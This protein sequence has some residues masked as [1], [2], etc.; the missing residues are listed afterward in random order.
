MNPELEINYGS[1]FENFAVC[2]L[3]AIGY[4]IY[5]YKKQNIGEIDFLIERDGGILPVEVKSGKD[6]KKHRSLDLLMSR[7][8]GTI[9]EAVVLSANNLEQS[10]PI[11]YCPIYMASL[12][13]PEKIPEETIDIHLFG[14][15]PS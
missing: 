3:T 11:L 6:Y 4:D 13:R 5:F 12:L 9:R 2:E 1:L 8:R 7:E 15:D 10:G 14:D